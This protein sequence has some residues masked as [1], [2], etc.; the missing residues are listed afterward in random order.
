MS[1]E[2]DKILGHIT[3]SDTK[4]T[5]KNFAD[6]LFVV[7]DKGI[8][9]CT[10]FLNPAEIKYCI[11]LM[12]SFGFDSYYISPG[13]ENCERNVIVLFNEYYKP[14]SSEYLGILSFSNHDNEINHRDILG[15]V[16][17]LGVNRSKIGDILFTE[18]DAIIFIKNSIKNYLKNNLLKVKNKNIS[19]NEIDKFDFNLVKQDYVKKT[20]IVSSLR[21]D[22]ICSGLINVSRRNA[23]EKIT[24]GDVKL[25]FSQN[26]SA[27]DIVEEYS[28]ISIRGFGRFK[29]LTCVGRTKKDNYIIEYLKYL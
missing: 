3:D 29:I 18:N 25:N 22:T 19:I 21:F 24:R 23:L 4:Q 15:A 7:M 16:L 12:N 28:V 13:L 20:M 1:K 17:S 2:L 14:E 8:D 11:Y 6:S 10:D 5:I 27:H 9:Y 26:K